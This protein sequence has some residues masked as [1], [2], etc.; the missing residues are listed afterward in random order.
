MPE[1]AN[2]G[3]AMAAPGEHLGIDPAQTM[4]FG[5]NLNDVEML[6]LVGMFGA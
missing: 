5:D 6:Q 1:G 4:A 3:T 2:K